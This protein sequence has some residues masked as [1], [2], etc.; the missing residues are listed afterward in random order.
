MIGQL[1]AVCELELQQIT[2]VQEKHNVDVREELVR[3]HSPP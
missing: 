2:F 3:D 1:Y